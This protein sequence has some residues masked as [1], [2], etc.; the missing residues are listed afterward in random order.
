MFAHMR[1]LLA[2]AVAV[3]ALPLGACITSKYDISADIKP[4]FPIKPGAYVNK[5]GTIIDVRKLG[6]EYRVYNRKNKDVSYARLYKIP[7]YSDY[8]FEFYEKRKP[9]IYYFF[10]KTTD[11]GFDFY[12]IEKLPSAVPEHITKLLGQVS[13]EER[14]NNV[15]T[16][17]NGK[18]D[19]LYVIREL[20][21]ANLKMV[22]IEKDSYERVP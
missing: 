16:V 20:A 11:K 19:T 12:D 9:P 5:E 4:E 8:I 21:R 10:L 2:V 22:K 14:K 17:A 3:V 6:N 18:R 15:I 13:D 1:R 7:E